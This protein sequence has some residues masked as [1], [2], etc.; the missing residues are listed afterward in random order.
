MH[1]KSKVWRLSN[2]HT[3]KDVES[4]KKYLSEFSVIFVETVDL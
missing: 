3:D 4:L 1:D 2:W